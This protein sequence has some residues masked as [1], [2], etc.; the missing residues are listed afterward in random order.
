MHH[1]QGGKPR[2]SLYFV[3]VQDERFFYLDPHTVQK[4]LSPADD[5]LINVIQH[6]LMC[7]SCVGNVYSFVF[8]SLPV[9]V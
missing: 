6:T 7:D 5:L 4:A 1:K 2:S 8:I 3:G 9:V